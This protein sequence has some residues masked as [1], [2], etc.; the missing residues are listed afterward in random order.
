MPRDPER[1][2]DSIGASRSYAIGVYR[3]M[4]EPCPFGMTAKYMIAASSPEFDGKGHKGEQVL[5]ARER[6]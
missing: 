4:A 1:V 2:P 5:P 6:P 3:E